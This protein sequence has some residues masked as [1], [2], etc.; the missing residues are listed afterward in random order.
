METVGL[1]ITRLLQQKEVLLMKKM[2]F[3]TNITN[4]LI[5]LGWIF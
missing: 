3:P 2:N 4:E 1:E 5:I